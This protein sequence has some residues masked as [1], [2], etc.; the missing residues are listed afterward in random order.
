M[1]DI[2]S[3]SED[4]NDLNEK[5][6]NVLHFAKY[7]QKYNIDSEVTIKYYNQS[8][9]FKTKYHGT[10]E[11]VEIAS[12]HS[13]IGDFVYGQGN[14]SGALNHYQ[15]ALNIYEKLNH[16]DDSDVARCLN[17][18]GLVLYATKNKSAFYY[19]KLALEKYKIKYGDEN[20]E[21]IAKTLHNIGLFYFEQDLQISLNYFE[22]SLTMQR[23]L[24]KTD[25][26]A[27]IAL[28]LNNMG[29]IFMKQN[30]LLEA[31]T[32]FQKVL[33]F[34]KYIGESL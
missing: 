31:L 2:Y 29:L 25:N 9:Q 21:E 28:V 17:N 4:E 32:Y 18:I 27:D 5:A 22:Q 14:H 19:Y 33:E 30:K 16:S 20:N 34:L 26:N 1:I 6:N 12:V 24:F 8:L 10:S 13:K 23:E 15:Q 11:H 3:K 7:F